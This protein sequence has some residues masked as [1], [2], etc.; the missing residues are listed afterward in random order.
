MQH[1]I[2]AVFERQNQAEQAIDDLVASGFSRDNVR[3]SQSLPESSG[4][5]ADEGSF[6]ASIKSFF[7]DIF[8]SATH[9]DTELYSEAV[10]QGHYVLTLDMADDDLVERATEVLDRHD[11]IDI[12][13][14]ANK[15]RAGGKLTGSGAQ[16]MAQQSSM[17]GA[18]GQQSSM[19]SAAAQS[20][21]Q[22][23][24]TAI[25][26]IQEALKVGKR[27]VE[28]GG[29]RVFRRVVETPV[30]ESVNLREENVTV[31][32]HAVDQPASAADLAAFQEGSFEVRETAEEA[33][34]EKVA[35]V[36]EEVV[37]GKE[38]TQREEQIQD[39]VRS[40]EVEVEQLSG[41]GQ[42]IRS[43][44]QDDDLYFRQHWNT[45]YASAGGSYDDYAPAYRYGSALG[46]R[47]GGRR[48]DEIEP[49]VRRGWESQYRGSAWKNFKDAVRHG[50]ERITS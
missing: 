40:T 31:E 1:T 21:S 29:V 47:Y 39:T 43:A 13:D 30:R 15:W 12:D 26:V 42:S 5:S 4:Q 9:P 19:Q 10:R 33:V 18:S 48:W 27:A 16:T 3:L 41:S 24:A 45:N 7:S 28:R 20:Q 38:V 11:P 22:S 6:G 37:I 23:G 34:V 32:R 36:V 49:D 14:E 25:P 8:G 2:A 35:R 50:W 44:T 46:E 17:Q